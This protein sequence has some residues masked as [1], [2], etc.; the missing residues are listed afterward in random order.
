[1]QAS[2]NERIKS[3]REQMKNPYVKRVGEY[4]LQ[5]EFEEGTED[6]IDDRLLLYARRKVQAVS[7]EEAASVFG[8]NC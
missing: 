5:I 6:S 3:V 7:G 2:G 4:T 8:G 1:M